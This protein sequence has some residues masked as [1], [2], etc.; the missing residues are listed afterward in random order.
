ME[1]K[2]ARLNFIKKED[3]SEILE[4]FQEPDT[5]KY[6]K[7]LDYKTREEYID[8]L[9]GR[10]IQT[11]EKEGYHWTARLKETNE[12]IGAMNLNPFQP[13]GKIQLGFQI[14]RKFWNQGFTSELAK[15]ILE[16]GIE[17]VGLTEIYGY[18][19]KENIASGKILK[20][21]GFTFVEQKS[22][23]KND[24]ALEV[25]KYSKT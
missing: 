12:F 9:T 6:I 5:F 17:E 20:K 21:L 16:F 10:I 7:P 22:F 14:K 3:F 23:D 11:F 19:E 18:F 24:S 8:I 25:Y 4:M 1:T 15:K 13:S 2:R